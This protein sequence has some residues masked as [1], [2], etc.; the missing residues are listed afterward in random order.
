MELLTK[1]W[2][3]IGLGPNDPPPSTPEAQQPISTSPWEQIAWKKNIKLDPTNTIV[4]TDK[5]KTME[6]KLS[7]LQLQLLELDKLQNKIKLN[8]AESAILQHKIQKPQRTVRKRCR[9]LVDQANECLEKTPDVVDVNGKV[10][11]PGKIIKGKVKPG[12]LEEYKKLR[13]DANE[14]A[15]TLRTR[16]TRPFN[17]TMHFYRTVKLRANQRA[18]FIAYGYLRGKR[19]SE[20]ET[21]PRWKRIFPDRPQPN[22]NKV[23]DLIWEHSIQTDRE[24]RRENLMNQLKVWRGN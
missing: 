4:I 7:A 8:I 13:A 15:K 14:L 20:I 2:K 6:E 5:E 24:W 22:W 18:A 10:I 19:Y 9:K 16:R 23:C 1:F 11:K 12:K 21:D 17:T 3:M